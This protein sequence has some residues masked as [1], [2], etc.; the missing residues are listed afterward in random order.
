M[1]FL[2]VT[3]RRDVDEWTRGRVAKIPQSQAASGGSSKSRGARQVRRATKAERRYSE[4]AFVW[5]YTAYVTAV[6]WIVMGM[7]GMMMMGI[8]TSSDGQ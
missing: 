3:E 7:V 5:L 8:A 6:W 1:V 4:F 2:L